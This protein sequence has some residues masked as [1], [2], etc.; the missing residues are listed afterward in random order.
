MGRGGAARGGAGGPGRA[1]R[2]GR[3]REGPGRPKPPPRPARAHAWHP[4]AAPRPKP[5]TNPAGPDGCHETA[6]RRL[7]RDRLLSACP[8]E[9]VQGPD[10]TPSLT[11]TGARGRSPHSQWQTIP[12]AV[13]DGTRRG[14]SAPSG[15]GAEPGT[16]NPA[17]TGGRNS[18]G[19]SWMGMGVTLRPL[20]GR[21]HPRTPPRR[22]GVTQP[23]PRDRNHPRTMPGRAGVIKHPPPPAR[24]SARAQRPPPQAHP[25][26]RI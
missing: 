1:A 12:P 24:A 13:A 26:R 25:E 7:V 2:G 20:G 16:R 4:A 6:T 14:V 8:E 18:P 11:V 17:R 9:V 5:P 15:G 10:T 23:P 21:N 3:A 22:T 19:V